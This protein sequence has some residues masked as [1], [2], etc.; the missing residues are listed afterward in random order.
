MKRYFLFA[1]GIALMGLAVLSQPLKAQIY[2]EFDLIQLNQASY[3]EIN[4]PKWIL[5]S[6]DFG[7]PPSFAENRKDGYYKEPIEL[8]FQFEYNSEVYDRIW[9][10]VNGFACFTRNGEFPPFVAPDDQNALFV[11]TT[12][13]PDNVL[14]PFWGDHFYRNIDDEFYG[15]MPSEISYGTENN[16][17]VFVIQWKDLNIN[18]ESVDD[19]GNPIEVRSSVGN[20][21]LRLYK[22]TDQFSVQGDIEF[23]YGPVGGN[24]DPDAGNTIITKDCAVGLKG[25][26]GDFLNGLYYKRDNI[27]YD[28]IGARTEEDLTNLWPPSGGTDWRIFFEAMVTQNVDEWWGDGDA[29]FSKAL[30]EKHFGMPQNRFVTVN[31][32]RTVMRSVATNVPLD[33]VR[34]REAYHADVNHNGRYYYKQVQQEVELPGGILDTI[35]VTVREDIPWRDKHYADNLPEGINSIKRIFYQATEYDAAWMLHYMSARVPELPW[36]Y[37]T[38]V[39][40]GKVGIDDYRANGIRFGEVSPLGNGEYKIPVYLNGSENNVFG[41]RFELDAQVIDIQSDFQTWATANRVVISGSTDGEFNSES[42]I[43]YI[44][45]VS[46]KPQVNVFN[47]RYNDKEAEGFSA[48]LTSVETGNTDMEILSQNTPNP[49]AANTMINVNVQAEGNYTLAVFDMFGNKIRTIAN[50]TMTPGL[51]Q[52]TWDG[53][54]EAGIPVGSGVYVYR[55]IGDDVTISKKMV[56]SR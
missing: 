16:G 48:N 25:D 53:V 45:V 20:F 28:D 34:R 26:Q 27:P 52:Y 19:E 4:V 33:S 15:F 31:D 37:D 32:V 38:I 22:S 35:W 8:G 11:K 43:C 50:G 30:G 36:I 51:T 14:A 24:P 5:L 29:D 3:Q 49:F 18:Y 44:R 42:P 10:N 1:V 23:C 54:D 13:Y 40:Y 12:S 2:S 47:V 41:A 6:E 21:Q 39:R 46:E 56:I 7:L 55:L 17:N 9:I